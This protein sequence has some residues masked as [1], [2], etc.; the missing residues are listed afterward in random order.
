[1]AAPLEVCAAVLRDAAGRVLIAQ[2][3]PGRSHAG[4]WEFPGGK[5]EP[6][7]AVAAAT[8]RELHEELGI[9]VLASRPLL[10]LS[11]R[12]PER[13][14][15]LHAVAVEAWRGLPASREGQALAWVEP[16]ALPGWPIL[17]ADRPLLNL[18]RLPPLLAITPADADG[19]MLRA[20]LDATLAAGAGLLQLRAPALD[21]SAYRAVAVEAIARCRAAG[22]T[23]LLNADP[24]LALELGADGAHLNRARLA[25]CRERPLPR[26]QWLSASVHD[27]PELEQALRIDVDLLLIGP[28]L[29]TAS[30]PT[31]AP[32]GWAAA[33]ALM[34]RAG[35]PCYALG[36]LGAG[37]LARARAAG[38]HGVAGISGLW[39]SA[40]VDVG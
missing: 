28:V 2:R 30:H 5:L 36:G 29:P 7:E 33:G 9:E 34:R 21:A 18:L 22:A 14:V 26:G 39:R 15:R 25:V 4:E 16:A 1:M 23:L 35:R 13:E 12:Y 31:A 27:L 11:H 20:G 19:A 10:T 40:L 37:D 24:A 32:L 38:A 17:A 3:G 6:G 8:V